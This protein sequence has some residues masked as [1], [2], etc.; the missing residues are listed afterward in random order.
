MFAF[1]FLGSDPACP[2][3]RPEEEHF[4]NQVAGRDDSAFKG[5]DSSSRE[6]LGSIPSSHMAGDNGL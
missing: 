4:K 5:S 2:Q 1:F 3:R 6:G